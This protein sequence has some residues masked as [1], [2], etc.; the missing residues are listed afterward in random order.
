MAMPDLEGA[1]EETRRVNDTL[2]IKV[3]GDWYVVVEATQLSLCGQQIEL[4]AVESYEGAKVNINIQ[5]FESKNL[6]KLYILCE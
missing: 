6:S 2:R 1:M 5:D 3:E 4:E